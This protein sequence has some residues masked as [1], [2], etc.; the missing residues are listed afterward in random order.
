MTGKQITDIA[1][2]LLYVKRDRGSVT[3]IAN[4]LGNPGPGPTQDWLILTPKADMPK[5]LVMSFPKPPKAADGS[6]IYERIPNKISAVEAAAAAAAA[7]AATATASTP[8]IGDDSA[9]AKSATAAVA[10]V[11]LSVN[12]CAVTTASSSQAATPM[13]IGTAGDGV[14]NAAAAA[15]ASASVVMMTGASSAAAAAAT[16]GGVGGGTSSSQHMPAKSSALKRRIYDDSVNGVDS[17]YYVE[18]AES[19]RAIFEG[20]LVLIILGVSFLC[21]TLPPLRCA[22]HKM[23]ASIP[24]RIGMTVRRKYSYF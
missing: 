23:L 3:R 24:T 4:R 21:F 7:A 13:D 11:G 15:A 6:L 17:K 8:P 18:G 19:I 2:L 16:L 14:A 5:P 10:A 22:I 20:S 12:N 9:T 1:H